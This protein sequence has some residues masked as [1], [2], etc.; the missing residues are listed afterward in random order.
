MQ[1]NLLFSRPGI[2]S[3][4]LNEEAASPGSFLSATPTTAATPTTPGIPT[5]TVRNSVDRTEWE[6]PR[7]LLDARRDDDAS[8]T[9][10]TIIEVPQVKQANFCEL[11]NKL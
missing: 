3:T 11:Y 8:S 10:E 4:G 6:G 9:G 7:I 5:A 1:F 2:V